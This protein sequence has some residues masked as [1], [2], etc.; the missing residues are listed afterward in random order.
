MHLYS[1][2]HTWLNLNTHC[3]SDRTTNISC[4][5]TSSQRITYSQAIS[6]TTGTVIQC[7]ISKQR[8]CVSDWME[9]KV[10]FRGTLKFRGV[11]GGDLDKKGPPSLLPSSLTQNCTS[12]QGPAER[13]T[14]RFGGSRA[15]GA[16]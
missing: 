12:D 5:T 16:W 3:V 2:C 6:Q 7:A 1:L 15:R 9:Q 13:D 10:E 11:W 8:M 4:L 14:F